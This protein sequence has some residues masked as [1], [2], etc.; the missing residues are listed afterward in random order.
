MYM[1]L[2]INAYFENISNALESSLL[3]EKLFLV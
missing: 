3:D 1:N 2:K